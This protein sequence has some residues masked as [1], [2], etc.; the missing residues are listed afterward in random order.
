M[1]YELRAMTRETAR[2][3]ARWQYSGVYAFYTIREPKAAE[4]EMSK[5]DFYSVFCRSTLIGF[6]CFGTAAQIP[7]GQQFYRDSRYLDIGLGLAPEFCGQGRGQG[8]TEAG[9]YYAA[10]NWGAEGFRLSVASFNQRACR[11]Y[12]RVGFRQIGTF[13]HARIGRAPVEFIVMTCDCSPFSNS[14]SGCLEG[15]V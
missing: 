10:K 3:V 2:I 4:E 15:L 6:F 5:G 12:E 11:V 14:Q 13:Q 9:I 1:M 7:S 8:F